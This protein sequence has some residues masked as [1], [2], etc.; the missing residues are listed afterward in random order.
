MN[1]G[2]G[3]CDPILEHIF[4]IR[5]SHHILSSLNPF[6][7]MFGKKSMDGQQRKVEQEATGSTA[8][9]MDDFGDVYPSGIRLALL[10]VS[11]Y[12]GMFLVALVRTALISS[13]HTN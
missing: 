6:T 11:I 10:M 8:Q 3:R 12:I 4:S 13:R 2:L 9:P 7:A 5:P 1:V